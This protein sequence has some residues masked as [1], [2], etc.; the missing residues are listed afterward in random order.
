[1]EQHGQS[2]RQVREWCGNPV[3]LCVLIDTND[4]ERAGLERLGF[5]ALL[6]VWTGTEVFGVEAAGD[7]CFLI[8][9]GDDRHR[10]VGAV[11][12]RP[13]Q[14]ACSQHFGASWRSPPWGF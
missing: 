8:V 2:Q 4:V 14:A 13:H 6:P 3:G 7:C 10:A 1:M 11:I 12:S 5:F 9:A